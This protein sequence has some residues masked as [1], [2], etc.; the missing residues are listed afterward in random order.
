[1]ATEGLLML[2]ADLLARIMQ[3]ESH[4]RVIDKAGIKQE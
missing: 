4:S 3:Y 2:A 1:V